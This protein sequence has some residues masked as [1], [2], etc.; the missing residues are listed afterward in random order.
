MKLKYLMPIFATVSTIAHA[1]LPLTVEDLTTDKNRFKLDTSLSYYNQSQTSLAPQTYGMADLGNGR[2]I[3]LPAPAAE[4][5]SNTDMLIV[6]AGLRY[7]IS[8][9]WEV[10]VRGNFVHTAERYTIDQK[11]NQSNNRFLQDIYLGMQ[12]SFKDNKKFPDSLLFAEISAYDNTQ[13]L[14]SKSGSSVLVGGTVYTINDPI[15]LSLTGSYQYNGN[16]KTL[17]NTAVDLGDVLAINGVVGFAVN[18]DITLTGGVGIQYKKADNFEDMGQISHN[19]TQ[20]SLNL[21]MAYA[22]SARS[23]LTANVRT[24]I[25]GGNNSTL[26][27]GITTKLGALP[28]PLSEKYRQSNK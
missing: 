18:P 5:N 6:G 8:D 13:G 28:P 12:Y 17:H 24:N 19:Q 25:S 9:S 20:T 14:R 7:G 2:V 3:I 16:R 1:D 27:L 4:N 23:N 21:G 26:S 22:L 15:V 10:G 11:P